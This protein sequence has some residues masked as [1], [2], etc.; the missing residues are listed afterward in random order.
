M[1]CPNKTQPSLSGISQLSHTPT[2]DDNHTGLSSVGAGPVLIYLLQ[3][4]YDG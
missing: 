2:T 3:A 1:K 4:V